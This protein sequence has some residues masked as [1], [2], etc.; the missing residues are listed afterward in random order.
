MTYIIELFCQAR[1]SNVSNNKITLELASHMMIPV[2]FFG[3]LVIIT[4]ESS[5]F[6]INE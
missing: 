6:G 3:K 5:E 1:M 2:N 4:D